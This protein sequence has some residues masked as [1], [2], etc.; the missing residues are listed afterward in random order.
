MVSTQVG[1]RGMAVSMGGYWREGSDENQTLDIVVLYTV[2]FKERTIRF[3]NAIIAKFVLRGS[4][5]KV[6]VTGLHSVPG[7]TLPS[8]VCG[9]ALYTG[10]ADSW[11]V[12]NL[13][14]F[15][16]RPLTLPVTQLVDR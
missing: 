3:Q 16:M 7:D 4:L 8:S 9:V 6:C 10:R 13:V 2:L 12:S 5:I 1:A 11:S 14:S 15:V